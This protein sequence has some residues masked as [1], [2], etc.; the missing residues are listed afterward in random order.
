[1][2]HRRPANCQRIGLVVALCWSC[3]GLC[4]LACSDPV[5]HRMLTFF[6]DGV[7]PLVDPAMAAALDKPE[8]TVV[9]PDVDDESLEEQEVKAAE[10][11]PVLEPGAVRRHPPYTQY[12]C[13]AC[14]AM[15]ARQIAQTPQDGLCAQCHEDVPG[16]LRYVHG[17]VAVNDCLFCH[18]PHGGRFRW[19]LR[20][21]PID[22]CLQCHDADDLVE[23]AHHDG[24]EGVSCLDCHSGHGGA[25]RFFLKTGAP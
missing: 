2:L 8:D 12:K 10:P 16:N 19:M 9:D 1:M 13:G 17:P 24:T 20:A 22:I 4:G 15:G 7:P 5:R 21:E 3:L 14:H 18:E 11:E 25:D 6:F 23:G